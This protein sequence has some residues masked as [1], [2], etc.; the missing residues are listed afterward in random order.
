MSAWDDS[1]Y[2]LGVA[3]MDATHRE[4]VDLVAA[5]I[6]APDGEF[7]ALYGELR[8][9]TRRHFEDEAKLMRRCRFPAIGEHE[10]E[11][12]RVLGELAQFARGVATGRIALARAYVRDL[13]TWFSQHLATM[14]SALAACVKRAEQA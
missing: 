4:F 3:A 7:P 1:R 9:H 14:D 12:L 6:A 5:A 11:H 10:S 2:G 13:P 8:E